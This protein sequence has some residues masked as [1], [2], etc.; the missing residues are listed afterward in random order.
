MESDEKIY[1]TSE[2]NVGR[3]FH[4]SDI[5]GEEID[6]KDSAELETA[7]CLTEGKDDY[8]YISR[9]K[10]GRSNSL[11]TD[12]ELEERKESRVPTNTKMNT[13]WAVRSSLG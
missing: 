12:E 5:L 6:A 13:T 7:N 2:R 8:T 10:N 9:L 11:V 3:E 4:L 1:V